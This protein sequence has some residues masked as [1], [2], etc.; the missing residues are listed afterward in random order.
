MIKLLYNSGGDVMGLFKPKM[1]KKNI[2]EIDYNK[3]KEAGIKCLVFDLDNTLGLIDHK[4]CPRNTK[5][6]LKS[7]QEDFLILISSSSLDLE[8]I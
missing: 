3:L 1:Y 2:F 8:G 4:K 7:L 5:K 6:L